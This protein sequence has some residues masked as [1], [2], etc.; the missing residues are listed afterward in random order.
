MRLPRFNV[1]AILV[2][3]GVLSTTWLLSAVLARLSDAVYLPQAARLGGGALFLFLVPLVTAGRLPQISLRL[4]HA[5][6]T[7]AGLAYF[8]SPVLLTFALRTLPSGF[9]AIVYST[10]PLW[11][12]LVAHGAGFDKKNQYLLVVIGLG[13][14]L[15]GVLPEI[16]LRGRGPAAGI[17]LAGSV[18]SL[19]LG[20]WVSKRLFWLHSALDLNVWSMGLAAVLHAFLAV[21][22]HEVAATAYWDRGYLVCLGALSIG[23]TGLGAYLYRVELM[24]R[25]T[26]VIL[27]AAVPLFALGLAW[28]CWRE[29]PVNVFTLAGT[30]LIGYVIVTES[31]VGAPGHWMC[32]FLNND[33][34]QGDRLICLIDAFMRLL[35][36]GK[37][38]RVQ[39][40]N[41]SI[42][43]LGFRSETQFQKGD[44][45]VVTLPL[46]Q[47]W[48]SITIDAVV[49]HIEPVRSRTYPF[50]GGMQFKPLAAHR[51]QCLVEF[52]ARL[53]KAEE[54][55]SHFDERD[56]A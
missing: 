37:P 32:L 52:L 54:D 11:L 49:T 6:I 19:I 40:V 28:Y 50:A 3:A 9:V 21:V 10:L 46:G 33:K 8:V 45:V 29:T 14:F 51:Q 42:G 20:V 23:V 16:A 34:R 39:V 25:H 5:A 22:N 30:A 43:G 44:S 12:I 17:A 55:T 27:T 18:F 4:L 41:L 38:A 56:S 48:S 31:L 35:K 13:L 26:I 2:L 15:W 47:N 36:E 24:R 53:S 1:A 7:V